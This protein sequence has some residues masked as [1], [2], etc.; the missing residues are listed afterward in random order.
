MIK[1][2]RFLSI[3]KRLA[4]LEASDFEDMQQAKKPKRKLPVLYMAS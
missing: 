4:A 1:T 3:E 2:N